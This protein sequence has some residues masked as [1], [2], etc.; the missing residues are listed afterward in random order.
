MTFDVIRRSCWRLRWSLALFSKKVY[1]SILKLRCVLFKR[2]FP[3]SSVGKEPAW[4]QKIPRRKKWQPTPVLLP[5]ELHG[6]RSLVGYSPWCHKSRTQLRTNPP[7]LFKNIMLLH[8]GHYDINITFMCSG[9]TPHLCDL[10]YWHICFIAVLWSWTCISE[11][12]MHIW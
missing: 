8:T 10:L 9:R 2:V 7:P 6:Q 11:A 12:C 3:R 4:V 1:L 5:G